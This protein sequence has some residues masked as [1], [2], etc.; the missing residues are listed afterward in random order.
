MISHLLSTGSDTGR[1][2]RGFGWPTLA[3]WIVIWAEA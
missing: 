3:A 2:I 1:W